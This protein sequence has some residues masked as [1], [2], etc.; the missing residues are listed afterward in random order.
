MNEGCVVSQFIERGCVIP[1]KIYEL[2]LEVV[3]LVRFCTILGFHM[4]GA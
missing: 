2:P 1:N 3:V 4:E